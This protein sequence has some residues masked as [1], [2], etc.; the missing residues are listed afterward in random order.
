MARTARALS[1]QNS[2]SIDWSPQAFGKRGER[3]VVG[4]I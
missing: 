3:S 1:L 4:T 2:S